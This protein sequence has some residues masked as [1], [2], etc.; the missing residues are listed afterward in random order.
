MDPTVGGN[1]QANAIWWSPSAAEVHAGL[2]RQAAKC[3]FF[4]KVQSDDAVD[5]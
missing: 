3:I 5:L 4:S 1:V 2:V